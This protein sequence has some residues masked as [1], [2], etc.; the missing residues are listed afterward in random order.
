MRLGEKVLR[1]LP[2]KGTMY[3]KVKQFRKTA[4]VLEVKPYVITKVRYQK[5]STHGSTKLFKSMAHIQLQKYSKHFPL[6]G[7]HEG[8]TA[9]GFKN[10]LLLDFLI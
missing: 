5:Y 1:Q 6:S 2:Y 3:R 4:S 9:G 7:K 10:R 8:G